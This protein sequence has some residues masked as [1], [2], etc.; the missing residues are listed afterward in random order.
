MA[1]DGL[2]RKEE[3]KEE[4]L[5]ESEEALKKIFL[6]FSHSFAFAFSFC[7]FAFFLKAA[8]GNGASRRRF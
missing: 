5:T 3:K 7:I 2:Q 4:R 6:V 8:F 1:T